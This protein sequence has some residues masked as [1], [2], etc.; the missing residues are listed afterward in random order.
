[1]I[2]TVR[3][4]Y[5]GPIVDKS[6]RCLNDG[7]LPD[8][9]SVSKQVTNGNG[10]PLFRPNS[11][12]LIHQV[13]G[14]RVESDGQFTH[15]VELSL[16]R[17]LHGSNGRLLKTPDELHHAV[18]RLSEL[19]GV[20]HHDIHPSIF[21]VRRLDL[22]LNLPL[23]ATLI[24]ALH[25]NARHPGVR[26]ETEEYHNQPLSTHG[27]PVP[28]MAT[29]LNTVRLGGAKTVIQLYDKVAERLARGKKS[30]GKVTDHHLRCLRV[31]IQLRGRRHVAELFGKDGGDNLTLD[32]LDFPSC[33][34]VFRG[35]LVEFD[36]VGSVPSFKATVPNLLAI[37]NGHPATWTHLGGMAPL[38][39]YRFANQ[40][41]DRQYRDMRRQVHAAE[42]T[43]TG[44]RW[45]DHLPEFQ[46]PDV[47]EIDPSGHLS[48]IRSPYS[49][50]PLPDT[51]EEPP[52]PPPI[53]TQSN[54]HPQ[55]NPSIPL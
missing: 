19:L 10:S 18:H 36:P 12:C 33:Y 51:R 52:P 11:T 38:D 21:E 50:S 13:S 7:D 53:S 54:P 17:L 28:H 43:V 2:D 45:A 8:W 46:L 5:H 15:H 20:F 30:E 4:L 16:P 31:E 40:V 6:V 42:L 39:W 32:Q 35:I 55:P 34:R 48:L 1:M 25:R 14:L 22:A 37:L 49:W 41:D 47:V 23:D 29:Q 24:L 3:L 44:F 26:R 27:R 9:K